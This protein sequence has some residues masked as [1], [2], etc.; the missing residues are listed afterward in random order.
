[1]RVVRVPL[2]RRS[3]SILLGD[4][5]LPSLGS[6]CR[7]LGLGRRC[8]L[9][10]D[11]SVERLY[12]PVALE[13]LRKAGFEPELVNV[14]PGE[15]SKSV[16]HVQH[17]LRSLA[18]ARLDRRSFVVALGGGVVGDLAGFV[19]A[20]YLRGVTLVQ[21]P[22]TLLAQVDSSVGGKV[23]I[24]LPEGK[25]LVGAFHQPALVLCDLATLATLPERE[26]RAGMAEVVKY[27][28]I[29]DAS[30]FRRL[31]N[32]YE[33][34][35]ALE[36]SVLGPVIARCCAIKA[37][38]VS[39]DETESGPRAILNF[40]HTIG[41]ALEAVG[42]YGRWLHGEAVAIGMIAAARLSCDLTGLR[43][44]DAAR[45]ER[46]LGHLKLPTSVRLSASQRGRAM[47]AMQRDKKVRDGEIRFVLMERLG[48]V[49]HG[50]PIAPGR[51]EEALAGLKN[52]REAAV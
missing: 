7:E 41:H 49:R 29:R 32:S 12:A 22:T 17:C 28:V 43:P 4:G 40:G 14:P 11:S 46:L 38:V 3:Y 5:V 50:I 33:S 15:R 19:A 42:G 8:A 44:Q 23:G 25:N 31:E 6:R 9:I 1:M 10:T 36:P 18:Q 47:T 24:N 16:A 48:A 13:S 39:E 2:G 45:L 51:V 26:L 21:V 52:G 20:I 27:G 34:L 37:A 30:L 35:L